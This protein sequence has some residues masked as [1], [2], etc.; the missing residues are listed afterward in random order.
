MNLLEKAAANQL[1]KTGE[2]KKLSIKNQV[3]DKYD[4]YEIPL[5][6]LYYNDQNGRINTFYKKY[7]STHGLISPEPGDS[8]Y[9]KIF[10]NFIFESNIQAMKDTKLSIDE[11]S[12]QEPGVVLPDGRVIDG[13]RR[14]TALRMLEKERKIQQYFNAVILPLNQD[15][16]TDEKI[17]KE[18]EL[19]LQLGREERVSYDPI[20]RIFDVYNTIKVEKIM[21]EDEYKKASGAKST[22]GI[23]R[24]IR[25]AKLIIKFIEIVSP[26]GNPIDKFYLARDLKLDG[27]IEEIEGEINKLESDRKEEIKDA[28]LTYLIASKTIEKQNDSTR[29]MRDLKN[30]IIK[31]NDRLQYFLDSADDK[32]DII[33]DTFED[34]PI[35]SSNEL[36]TVIEQNNEA[37]ESVTKLIRSTDRL[38]NKGKIENERTK[39][40]IE[41]EN[42]RDSLSEIGSEDFSELT[43]DENIQ[44][45]DIISEITDILFRLRKDI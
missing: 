32:I 13:N 7:S 26:G 17:I 23:N 19:D 28:V 33:M 5:E 25:L 21:N 42:I 9:N 44:A 34:N 4:V 1:K 36:R 11:K 37:S 40:L 18:L 14:F 38:I 29:I 31:D 35:Q 43:Q 45:R 30:N 8:D 2:K 20:D 3:D 41:L 12:Q 6:L 24:D 39:A 22:K 16:K 10:E 15:S 27:P